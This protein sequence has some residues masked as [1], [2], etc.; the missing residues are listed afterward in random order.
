MSTP[1]PKKGL[2]LPSYRVLKGGVMRKV[3]GHA[4]VLGGKVLWRG[5]GYS[6]AWRYLRRLVDRRKIP[7]ESC[8]DALASGE[9]L[10]DPPDPSPPRPPPWKPKPSDEG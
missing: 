10:I 7:F 2:V 8:M 5:K 4:K 6:A 1:T 3:K 9:Y